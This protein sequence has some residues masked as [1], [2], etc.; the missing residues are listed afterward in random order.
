[1]EEIRS[2][3]NQERQIEMESY[4]WPLIGESNDEES[5]QLVGRM[6]DT[7]VVERFDKDV[8]LMIFRKKL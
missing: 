3:L 2:V 6:T 8:T 5:L 4:Y 1:M 7:A